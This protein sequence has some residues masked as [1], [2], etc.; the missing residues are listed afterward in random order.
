MNVSH[1][2]E[3]NSNYITNFENERILVTL[4]MQINVNAQI[5]SNIPDV[6][7]NPEDLD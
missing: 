7:S 5:N 6:S 3:T 1:S 2:C 4:L